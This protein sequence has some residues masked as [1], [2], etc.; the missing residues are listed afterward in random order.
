MAAHADTQ[1]IGLLVGIAGRFGLTADRRWTLRAGVELSG[2]TNEE[3][4]SFQDSWT[5]TQEG[6]E[7]ATTVAQDTTSSPSKSLL[8]TIDADVAVEGRI[9]ERLRLG[10]GYRYADWLEALTEERFP[11]AANQS[12]LLS[13]GLDLEFSGPYVRLAWYF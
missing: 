12:L 6:R 2:L 11:D 3:D 1:G 7:P 10:V 8:T 4:L 5:F 13:E 9:G